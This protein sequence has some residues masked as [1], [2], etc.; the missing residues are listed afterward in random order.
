MRP[1]DENI[2]HAPMQFRS[3]LGSVTQN[4]IERLPLRENNF[5]KPK[6]DLQEL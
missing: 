5:L 2:P 4:R 6:M 1:L 3:L